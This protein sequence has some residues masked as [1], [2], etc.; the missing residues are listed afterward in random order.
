MIYE[1]TPDIEERP[2]AVLPR[3]IVAGKVSRSG[4]VFMV[5]GQE[6]RFAGAPSDWPTIG[7]VE[8]FQ[9]ETRQR[10][11]ALAELAS[12]A[13]R[14][15]AML[16]SF[17]IPGS[18]F[19]YCTVL[20]PVDINIWREPQFSASGINSDNVERIRL[21]A[22]ALRQAAEVMEHWSGDVGKEVDG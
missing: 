15:A 7:E 19:D 9:E 10:R 11:Q 2:V 5:D 21:H 18:M 20:Q 12:E 14:L 13:E 3:C 17:A 22:E 16:W 6:Q 1:N 8:Q 4:I